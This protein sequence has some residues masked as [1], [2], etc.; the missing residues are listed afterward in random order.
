MRVAEFF[1]SSLYL[2]LLVIKISDMTDLNRLMHLMQTKQFKVASFSRGTKQEN[3]D[4]AKIQ[5]TQLVRQLNN[6]I[7][8]NRLF[9]KALMSNDSKTGLPYSKEIDLKDGDIY[10]FA[11]DEYGNA[12]GKPVMYL[13]VKVA[14][15]SEYR[16]VFSTITRRSFD[17]FANQE[18]HY[19]WVFNMDGTRSVLIDGLMFYKIVNNNN[20]WNVSKKPGC[21]NNRNE[22]YIMG[23]WI[24]EY[25][26]YFEVHA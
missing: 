22:D 16:Y 10:I 1:G 18:N 20:P 6:L 15:I 14:F 25:R 11:T 2:Q 7:N 5:E 21:A 4:N 24:N 13:D 17:N 23:K 26:K 3:C 9:L 19:Y 8:E 12:F